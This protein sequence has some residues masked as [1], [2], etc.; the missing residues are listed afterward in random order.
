VFTTSG[1]YPW[2]FVTQEFHSGQPSHGCYS[3][4]SQWWLE[5]N[6]RGTIG[7]VAS[8]LAA[9]LYRE[10]PDKNH[11]LWNIGSTERHALHTQ[12]LLEWLLHINGKFTMRKFKSSLL[13]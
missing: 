3:K 10:N 2:S 6:R 11:K 9:T 7:S 4:L 8:L 12:V 1:T 13:W 5:F